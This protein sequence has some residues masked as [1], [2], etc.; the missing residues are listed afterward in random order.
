METRKKILGLE[1]PY[2]L[3][4]MH[5]LALTFKSQGQWRMAEELFIQ[6]VEIRKRVLGVEHPDTLASI[7]SL[8]VVLKHKEEN[9][10]PQVEKDANAT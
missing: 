6:V 8:A 3:T 5:N 7:K 2:T 1:H 4:S 9:K 10:Y